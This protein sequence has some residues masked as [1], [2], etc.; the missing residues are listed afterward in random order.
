MTDNYQKNKYLSKKIKP[1]D[2]REVKNVDDLLSAL[3][4]CGFQGRNLGKALDILEKM[5]LDDDCLTVLTLSGAM[6]PAGMGEL[7][8]VLMEYNLIDVLVTTGAN[9]IHDLVD[10]VNDI[11][12]YLG[13]SD[14]DD[15]ELFRFR[16]NRIYDVFLPEENY[17]TTE[18]ELL[19]KIKELFPEK[20]VFIT[21]SKLF[22]KLGEKLDYRCILSIAAKKK[23]PIFVPAFSDSEF[24]L[25]LYVF[26]KQEGFDFQFDILKE[27]ETFGDCIR[28][29]K[30]TGTVIIG[31][32]VPRNWAQQIFPLLDQL[33]QLETIGYDYSVRIHTAIEYDGGLSGCTVTESKSWGKY[34]LDS[35]SVSVWCDATI[36]L[37]ILITG[38]LQRLELI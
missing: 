37:P 19:L 15:G 14:V 18:K 5:V 29:A 12:H 1:F 17:L 25:D 35:K 8:C 6:V 4:Y 28:K 26:N 30:K 16:I 7:I 38:L 36:A 2:P 21:P 23:I 32:G 31:G 10:G 27:I 33:E 13:S 11:G 34:T 22:A 20:K 9:I 24:A 3:K